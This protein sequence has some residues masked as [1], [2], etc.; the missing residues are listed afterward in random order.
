[1]TSVHLVW[2]HPRT[3]SLTA[4]TV[5]AIRHELRRSGVPFT[6]IDLYRSGFDP[7]LHE[8]D[9]PDWGRAK[10]YSEEVMHLAAQAQ[11]ADVL[12]FVFPTWWASVPAIMKGYIDRVFNYG[13]A[14]GRRSELGPKVW[15]WITPVGE[16]Y[17]EFAAERHADTSMAH[18]LNEG[19]ARYSGATDSEVVFLYNALGEGLRDLPG[20]HVQLVEQ[21]VETVR[22]VLEPEC[23]AVG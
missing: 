9:E 4:R 20:H 1:M 3:D 12:I 11:E 18:V 16:T 7:R 19:I 21:A 13:I 14:Y 17:E 2:A 8:A 23:V 10:R 22:E 6:E 15:R 5:A